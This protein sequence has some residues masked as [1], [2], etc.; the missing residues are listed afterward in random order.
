MMKKALI[1]SLILHPFCMFSQKTHLDKVKNCPTVYLIGS[2][3]N[4]HFNSG[5]NYSLND[6]CAQIIALEPDIVCGEI[7]AEA[8]KQPMEGYYPPES[9]FL[10]EMADSLNYRFIPVDWR[11]DFATQ[12]LASQEFPQSVKGQRNTIL[13]SLQKRMSSSESQSLY[14]VI[15]NKIFLH[16]LNS[17]YEKIIGVNAL[18]E[19]A[20]GSWHE[21][22][23]RIVENGLS[24]IGNAKKIVFVFG[25]DHI[26]QLQRQLKALG[27]N[28]Q[29]PERMFAPSNNNKV[30]EAVLERWKI[31]LKNIKL[32]RDNEIP[33]NLDNY[34]KVIDSKRIEDLEEALSKSK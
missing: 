5:K 8:F 4:M 25:I 6:L 15:H 14:D 1:I 3:H 34:Q 33:S 32:I 28:A 13:N 24:A 26:P 16:D 27:I 17:L 11:L 7:T 12:T 23:R 9:A 10:A 2:V 30:T 19:I 18:A 22:N 21:R 31:N 29:I 20:C